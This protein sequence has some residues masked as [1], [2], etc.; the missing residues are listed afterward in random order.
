MTAQCVCRRCRR[1]CELRSRGW[2]R[3]ALKAATA[4]GDE[5]GR[6]HGAIG[7]MAALRHRDRTGEGQHVDVALLDTLTAHPNLTLAA[8]GVT[9]QRN[10][11]EFRVC[12]ACECFRL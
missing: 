4:I 5:L 9:P 3:A 12:G 8:M 1:W 10:G 11:N 6:L 2:P 7:A